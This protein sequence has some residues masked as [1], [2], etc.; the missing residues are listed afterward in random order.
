MRIP[1]FLA[2]LITLSLAAGAAA[3]Q[4]EHSQQTKEDQVGKVRFANSC[5]AAMPAS[6]CPEA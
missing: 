5:A 3:A 2:G 1:T 6:T 4:H